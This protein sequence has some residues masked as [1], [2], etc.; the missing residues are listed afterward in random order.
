MCNTILLSS[1]LKKYSSSK[2][3][4]G[5]AQF[6]FAGH[7]HVFWNQHPRSLQHVFRWLKLRLK[8]L[9]GFPPSA[10]LLLLLC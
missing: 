3:S 5:Y 10:Q 8:Y 7:V 9:L 1:S 6:Q 4:T 2:I